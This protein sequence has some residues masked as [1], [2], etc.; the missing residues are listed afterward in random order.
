MEDCIL[1]RRSCPPEVDL[2]SPGSADL[3]AYG[4]IA[5]RLSLQKRTVVRFVLFLEQ[6]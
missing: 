1:F 5:Y 3:S 4:V 6:S 2:A